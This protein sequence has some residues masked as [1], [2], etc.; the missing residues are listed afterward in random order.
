MSIQN[1]FGDIL[2]F[3]NRGTDF[4]L[5]DRLWKRIL[6]NSLPKNTRIIGSL[7]LAASALLFVEGVVQLTGVYSTLP[8][9]WTTLLLSFVNGIGFSVMLSSAMALIADYF[10]MPPLGIVFSDWHS[11]E[12]Y[13]I[14]LLSSIGTALIASSLKRIY[15]EIDNATKAKSE[16]VSHMSHEIRT[17]LNGIIGMAALLGKT[18]LDKKQND[19]LK[20]I[21]ESSNQL[22]CV[23]NDVLDLSKVEANKFLLEAKPFHLGTL[24]DEMA[25]PFIKQAE[26]KQIQFQTEKTPDL[27]TWFYGD[28]FRLKQV[29]SNVLSNAFKFTPRGRITVKVNTLPSSKPSHIILQFV[30][31]DTGIGMSEEVLKHIFREFFQGSPSISKKYGGSG[32]GLTICKKIIEQMNGVI[33]AESRVN[34]GSTFRVSLP[35]EVIK[36]ISV[37][38]IKESLQIKEERFQSNPKR[39]GI[40]ILLVED[41]LINQTVVRALLENL[42]YQI[43]TALDGLDA[44]ELTRTKPY[45]LILMDLQM[46]LLNGYDTAKILRMEGSTTPIVAF[47]AHASREDCTR[48]FQSGMSDYLPKPY[49]ERK[50]IEMVDRW[51]LTEGTPMDSTPSFDRTVL[52]QLEELDQGRTRPG[53]IQRLITLYLDDAPAALAKMKKNLQSSEIEVLRKEAH[54]FKSSNNNLGLKR[55][56]LLLDKIESQNTPAFQIEGLLFSVENETALA[57]QILQEYQNTVASGKT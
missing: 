50:L 35:L 11:V 31:N 33:R 1:Y 32:L 53:L 22:L 3:G 10:L 25:Y 28:S 41:N 6:N 5:V 55:N 56:A 52:N 40:R 19:F 8:L 37:H 47:T 49:T 7:L 4:G 29:L 34:Q 38:E 54:R 43:D 24:I 39:S 13:L 57:I 14:F 48:A 18:P 44:L 30:V 23:V 42:G 45:S 2:T 36:D 46:P 20:A 51:C 15:V 16:F 9:L 12:H 21:S 27:E 26:T 17:P